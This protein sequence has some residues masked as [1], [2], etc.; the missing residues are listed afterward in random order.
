M[1]T[2]EGEVLEG[3]PKR[4]F[5]EDNDDDDDDDGDNDTELGN[6]NDDNDNIGSIPCFDAK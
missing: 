4:G 3:A 6:G 1:P 2:K 5:V